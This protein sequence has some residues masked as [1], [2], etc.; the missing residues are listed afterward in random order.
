MAWM[1]EAEA[2]RFDEN[3][4]WVQTAKELKHYFPDL[5]LQQT[6]EKIRMKLR[7]SDRYKTKGKVTFENIKQPT[8]DDV[9]FFYEAMKRQNEAIMKLETKQNK[10]TRS[11]RTAP[12]TF[13]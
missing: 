4:S 5:D 10:A 11:R 13:Q 12:G 2:L 7:R 9:A 8:E 6:V 1:E 3:R